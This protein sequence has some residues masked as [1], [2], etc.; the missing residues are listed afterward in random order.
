MDC[1]VGQALKIQGGETKMVRLTW[2]NDKYRIL[3]RRFQGDNQILVDYWQLDKTCNTKAIRY[4]DLP[5]Y[6]IEKINELKS[7]ANHLEGGD[8]N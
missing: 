8:R 1:H 3:V 2:E 5:Q 6:V 4:K 7:L